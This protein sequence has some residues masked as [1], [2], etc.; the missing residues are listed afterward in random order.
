MLHEI[1]QFLV[2]PLN[3]LYTKLKGST[4]AVEAAERVCGSNWLYGCK[5]KEH[6]IILMIRTPRGIPIEEA[7]GKV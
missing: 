5:Q 2:F 3:N 1:P 6:L 4:R 7:L